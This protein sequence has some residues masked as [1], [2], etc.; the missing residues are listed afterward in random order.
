M[1]AAPDA[2]ISRPVA[3]ADIPASGLEVTVEATEAERAEIARRF[4]T[5]PIDRLVGSFSLKGTNDRILV[6]GTVEAGLTQTCVVTLEPFPNTLREAVEV[7]FMSP[8]ALEQ[9]RAAHEVPEEGEPSAEDEPDEIVGG[10]IDLGIVTAE[11]FALGL[12]PYPRKPGA[13]FRYENSDEEKVSPFAVLK[14]LSKRED[15]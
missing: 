9:W 1:T 2:L 3:V 10:T 12:D 8:A 15:Q 11:F 5:G 7:T 6:T 14:N 13:Q 4:G